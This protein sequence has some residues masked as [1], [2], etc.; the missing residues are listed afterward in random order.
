[1]DRHQF[2]SY[3]YSRPLCEL[4][5][6][7]L[8]GRQ[9]EKELE[10]LQRRAIQA[11][12]PTFEAPSTR[13]SIVDVSCQTNASSVE[14]GVQVFVE[15]G[16]GATGYTKPCTDAKKRKSSFEQTNPASH[17][18][19][20]KENGSSNI[21]LDQRDK[22]SKRGT[23]LS[24]P[25]KVVTGVTFENWSPLARVDQSKRPRK[26]NVGEVPQAPAAL[27]HGSVLQQH[28]QQPHARGAAAS[29]AIS[30]APRGNVATFKLYGENE[31]SDDSNNGDEGSDEG[32]D[33]DDSSNSGDTKRL[34]EGW[35]CIECKD[36]NYTWE[37]PVHCGSCG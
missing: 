11:S 32:D 9:F 2:F 23:Q 37:Y 20:K 3:L 15:T 13:K 22:Q 34:F 27:R 16:Q 26:T 28:A 24:L 21:L 29:P 10:E 1:M 6:I 33:S 31:R 5:D 8:R 4:K 18:P 30:A 12:C 17:E 14:V 19:A 35:T 7:L 36:F 25:T